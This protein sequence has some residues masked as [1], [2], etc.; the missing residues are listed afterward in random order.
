[1]LKI[2]ISLFKVKPT[3]SGYDDLAIKD[4]ESITVIEGKT[5]SRDVAAIRNSE[6]FKELAKK[7]SEK[8]KT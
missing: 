1:M 2:L 6:G 5:V 8:I 7:I 3:N 4:I